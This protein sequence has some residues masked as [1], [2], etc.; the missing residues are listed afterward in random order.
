LRFLCLGR[1]GAQQAENGGGNACAWK[2]S[3][4]FEATPELAGAKCARIQDSVRALPKRI[5]DLQQ[6]KPEG[7][8]AIAAKLIQIYK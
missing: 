2:I 8:A 7:R 4:H 5:F 1:A 6:D 3:V